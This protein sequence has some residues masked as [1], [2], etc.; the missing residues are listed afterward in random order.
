MKR[1]FVEGMALLV[2]A[3]VAVGLPV[4]AP[5]GPSLTGPA[6][7][8]D[9]DTLA[10]QGTRVR[11]HGI[12]A[13]ESAQYCRSQGRPWSARLAQ[14]GTRVQTEGLKSDIYRI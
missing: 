11:L 3:V 9:G 2:A 6:R 4:I 8:I 10:V 1:L 13:P 12:D 5:A 7:I 14:T